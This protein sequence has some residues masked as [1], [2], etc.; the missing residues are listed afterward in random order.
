MCETVLDN[1]K[2]FADSNRGVFVP[3]YFA[4]SVDRD[5]VIGIDADDYSILEVGPD[6]EYYWETWDSVLTNAVLT[7][8]S[9][10]KWILHHD[11]DLWVIPSTD[12]PLEV[13]AK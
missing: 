13:K 2:L 4:E 10:R 3:Q 1:A 6:H 8:V 12:T 11:G 5:K 9:G 7:D